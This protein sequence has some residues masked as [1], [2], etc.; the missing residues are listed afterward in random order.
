[1]QRAAHV[2][3]RLNVGGIARFLETAG[4]AVDILVR[5]VVEGG[6]AEAAWSGEQIVIPEMRRSLR[7]GRDLSALD[8]LISELRNQRATVVHTHASKAGVL[9]RLAARRLG[10]PCV[11]TFHGHVLEGY[12]PR[13]ISWAFR[14]IERSLARR[15]LVTA[16]G[17]RTAERLRALLE[18]PVEVVAP[19][20]TLP[21]ASADA[22]ARWR[23]SWGDP[24][25]VALAVARP[26]AGKGLA[27]FAAASRAAGYLPVV[28]GA[29]RVKGALALGIVDRVE[30]LYAACDVVVSASRAEGTPYSLLEAAWAGRPVVAAPAG[31]VDWVVG[32]GGLVTDNLVDGLRQLRDPERRA[33]LGRCAA[34]AVRR[35][36]DPAALAPRLRELYARAEKTAA[37]EP[38]PGG[39]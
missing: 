38:A 13:P 23:E 30:E 36:F 31:D 6:E 3:T 25:R 19:G 26:V 27:R 28:A 39:F 17:P 33:E 1:M 5:G 34:D 37:L 4:D 7:F 16:T 10:L 22:R 20:V 35:R 9:G 24:E 21:E 2:V 11:H 15:S 18:S 14:R 8:A 29:D 32:N 12:F